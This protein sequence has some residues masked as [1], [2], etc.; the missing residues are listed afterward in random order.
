MARVIVRY[1]DQEEII[2]EFRGRLTI[3]R[4]KN[5]DV[6]IDDPRASRNHAEILPV[7]EG[8]YRLTDLGSINGTWVNG[9]RL[10]APRDLQDGDE[11]TI[12]DVCLRF[13]APSPP[14]RPQAQAAGG[15]SVAG[16]AIFLRHE[17]VVILVSDIR[18]FTRM[19]EVLPQSDF[20]SLISEW[21]RECREVVES[22]GGTIDKFMG[23]AVM[24]YW[25]AAD[26]SN[27]GTEVDAA[28]DAAKGMTAR[29]EAL[30]VRLS[31]QFAGQSF[32][33]GVGI[34]TGDAV[35]GN[36]EKRDPRSFTLMG[37]SVN[38]AFRLESLTKELGKA[39]IV[40]KEV[41]RHASSRFRFQDLGETQVKGRAEAVAIC[42]LLQD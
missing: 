39:A 14:P 19:S 42:A 18:G 22:N 41:S 5:N 20:S 40:S 34:N 9:R 38:I 28:L 27:P 10:S 13:A 16:T 37:D 30:S 26:R 7:R 2:I 3:G 36:V 25:I 15:K 35:L 29:A 8:K 33:I 31:R 4:T 17:W 21:F 11:I 6:V 24:A 12:A 23:D 1:P 32:R